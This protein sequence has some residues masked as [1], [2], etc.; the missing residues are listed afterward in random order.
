[1][2][3]VAVGAVA[4]AASACSKAD[5]APVAPAPVYSLTDTI[6]AVEGH[7]ARAVMR[8]DGVVVDTIDVAFGI[9]SVGRDSVLYLPA[10]ADGAMAALVLYHDGART[11]LA[12][13]VPD[14]DPAVS[15]PAVI[16]NA[17]LYWGIHG[18]SVRAIRY[19]FPRKR[20]NQLPVT[21]HLDRS[22]AA[23]RFTPPFLDGK[24]IVFKAPDG[25]WRFRTPKQ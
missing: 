24:E 1:V 18:D 23:Y 7:A 12:S 11:P 10:H 19:E 15:A 2:F 21:P 6:A 13:L 4:V 22:N 20:L 17:V 9:Q 25:E 8:R 5:Q 3:T 14:Y 16:N